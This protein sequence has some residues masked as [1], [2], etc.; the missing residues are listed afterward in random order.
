MIYSV[1]ISTALNALCGMVQHCRYSN[2]ILQHKAQIYLPI[3]GEN[4]NVL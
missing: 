2:A 4:A 1:H 3:I